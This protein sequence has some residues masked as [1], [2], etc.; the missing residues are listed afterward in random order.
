M[1][2]N[3]NSYYSGAP[4]GSTWQMG[5]ATYGGVADG[6]GTQFG[7]GGGF[8]QG[9]GFAPELRGSPGGSN[10]GWNMAPGTAGTPAGAPQGGGGGA[11]GGGGGGNTSLQSL[12]QQQLQLGS[13]ADAKNQAEWDKGQGLLQGATDSYNNSGIT[14]AN[15]TMTAQLQ[16][17]PYSINA[18]TEANIQGNAMAQTQS[19]NNAANKQIGGMM[20]SSGQG[21]ASSM[22]AL[23]ER[24]SRS[25]QAQVNQTMSNLSVQKALQ[26]KTDQANAIRMGQQQAA[27]DY[28][29][30]MG[31]ATTYL[32]SMPQ[33]KPANLSGF[34][35]LAARQNGNMG[36]PGGG[37]GGWSGPS[38]GGA[39]TGGYRS[40]QP[41]MM[42]QGGSNSLQNWGSVPA[43]QYAEDYGGN[44]FS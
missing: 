4:A 25:G 19:A 10:G 26:D 40:N 9:A 1:A 35:A 36:N 44:G 7:A 30:N 20:A 43:P 15:R 31:Q 39:N 21:D 17:D 27:Q 22:A 11:Y 33:N 41:D 14:G 18:G 23:A 5:N 3:G 6:K 12:L 13:Q 32:N 38:G 34:A 29:V 2:V 28:G 16:A 8:N 37:G 42:H 24:Q